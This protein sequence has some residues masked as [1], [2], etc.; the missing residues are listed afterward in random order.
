MAIPS[1]AIYGMGRFGRAL[2]GALPEGVL[3]RTGGRSRAPHGYEDL[4]A[5]GPAA[6]M[7]DLKAELV[8]LSVPDDAL[9]TVAAEL[10]AQPG[11]VGRFYVHTSGARGADAIIALADSDIGVFHILQ[12][13]PLEGGSAL[14]PG[15]YATV[16]GEPKLVGVLRELAEVLKLTVLE[17][18]D[19]F[20]HA[21]YHAAAVLASNALI[22]LLD[23]GCQLLMQAGIPAAQAEKMLIPL[24]QGTLQ[25][26]QSQGLLDALTGPVARG[27]VGT[28]Q[29][30][31]SILT[32]ESRQAYI[33]MML[34]VADTAARSG[35]TPSDKLS[36]IRRLL[37][38]T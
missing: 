8:I 38:Q 3:V 5:Q 21:A 15:S 37:T 22:A 10:A 6:F 26:A 7:H 31:L 28:I 9:E 12:S 29:Q 4:H 27:D 34:S 11:A 14:I 20:D 24:A 23:T 19:P 32:G 18:P 13:F 1:I 30:H 33:A 16:A 2:A 25:N 35:R 36:E 17:Q